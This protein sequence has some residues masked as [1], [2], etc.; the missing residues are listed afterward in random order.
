MAINGQNRRLGFF[1]ERKAVKFLK[2]SGYKIAERNFRCKAGEIDVIA[3][4]GET[5]AFIEVK[6]RSSDYF[7]EPN[8]AV[9]CT[10]RHRYIN[11]A[12]QYLYCNNLRPDDYILR[13]DIIEVTKQGINHIVSAFEW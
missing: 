7:G 4:K 6:T 11:A 9:D 3:Q 13:F 2:K 10:R 8:E 1:G 12:K 5:I